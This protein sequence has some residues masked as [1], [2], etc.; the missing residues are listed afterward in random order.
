VAD[1]PEIRSQLPSL[2][3]AE[4]QLQAAEARVEARQGEQMPEVSLFASVGVEREDDPDFSGDDVT[5]TVGVRLT[6]NVWDGQL[7]NEQVRELEAA[8]EEARAGREQAELQ[9]RS[10][11]RQAVT[12]LQASRQTLGLTL[13][14]LELSRENRELVE[15]SYRAGRETL[16]R[17]N[18]AQ[19]D[20]N[21]A[22]ARFAAARL[23]L[24][25]N[26]LDLMRTT[27][28]LEAFVESRDPA[29]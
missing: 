9:A 20:F 5:N 28:T 29:E 16:I 13:K 24:Q 8:V 21:N 6:W 18:E 14:T 10:D 27:G 23:Q 1:W 4:W 25:L 17:L 15:A 2:Q 22:G 3:E 11:F 19:R 26:Y 7:I 12:R